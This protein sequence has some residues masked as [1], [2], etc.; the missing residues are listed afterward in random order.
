MHARTRRVRASTADT[1]R[2]VRPAGALR[3]ACGPYQPPVR[4][5][6]AGAAVRGSAPAARDPALEKGRHNLPAARG[7]G[8]GGGGCGRREEQGGGGG[9]RAHVQC[10]RGA[11]PWRTLDG[12]RGGVPSG[13]G[14]GGSGGGG[15][16]GGGRG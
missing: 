1:R 11:P 5:A 14:G 6:D 9:G 2:D 8:G 13:S 15:G 10:G 12:G 16:G 7:R 3:N 4:A